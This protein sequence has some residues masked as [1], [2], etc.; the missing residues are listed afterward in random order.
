MLRGG[1]DQGL[2][3]LRRSAFA[4]KPDEGFRLGRWRNA[5][6]DGQQFPAT[7]IDTQSLGMPVLFLQAE[8]QAAIEE[9]IQ[10]VLLQASPIKIAGRLP[11]AGL[12]MVTSQAGDEPLEAAQGVV[13]GGEQPG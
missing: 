11:I 5:E 1:P 2:S 6:N 12:L 3:G 4:R 13:T 7:P 10:I 8:D 9:F